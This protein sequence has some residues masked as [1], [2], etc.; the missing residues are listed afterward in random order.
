M[1]VE[2]GDGTWQWAGGV[3]PAIPGG[4][5]MEANTPYFLASIDKLYNATLVMQRA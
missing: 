5:A 2:S 1:A 3:G 4:P